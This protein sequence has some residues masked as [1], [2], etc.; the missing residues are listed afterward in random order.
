VPVTEDGSPSDNTD[1]I[2]EQWEGMVGLSAQ[3]GPIKT[4]PRCNSADCVA[5]TI[6]AVKKAFWTTMF[7]DRNPFNLD[8]YTDFNGTMIERVERARAGHSSREDEG[9]LG[10]NLKNT[11]AGKR[12]FKTRLGYIGTGPPGLAVGDEIR[13][14]FDGSVPFVVRPLH[15]RFRWMERILKGSEKRNH[16][17]GYPFYACEEGSWATGRRHWSAANTESPWKQPY[18]KEVERS[19]A[20]LAWRHTSPMLHVLNFLPKSALGVYPGWPAT[21]TVIGGAHVYGAMSHQPIVR[22]LCQVRQQAQIN[23][24]LGREVSTYPATRPTPAAYQSE[25]DEL[26]QFPEWPVDEIILA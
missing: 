4:C 15:N 24:N 22:K 2:L 9:S 17:Y 10:N 13:I 26:E 12:L 21:H 11:I 3:E 16:C 6:E 18:A 19:K 8:S 14:L 20:L 25:L 5:S 23:K 7:E 1:E